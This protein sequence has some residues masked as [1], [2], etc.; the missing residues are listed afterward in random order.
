VVK[1]VI[2]RHFLLFVTL[3]VLALTLT[4]VVQQILYLLNDGSIKNI[5]QLMLTEASLSILF[6]G[7]GIVLDG[8]GILVSWAN[9]VSD[10]QLHVEDSLLNHH[11]EYYG[12]L[13]AGVGLLIE[14]IDQ[15]CKFFYD[16]DA[17]VMILHYGVSFPLNI[18]GLV[19]LSLI[20]YKLIQS[21]SFQ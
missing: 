12:L 5:H 14:V 13:I 20:T 7:L 2:H 11:C 18:A 4:T 3:L 8:R 9:R 6:V 17:V 10:Q 16:Q 21:K 1:L 15:V 19:M